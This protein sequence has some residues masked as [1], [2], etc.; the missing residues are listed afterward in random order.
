MKRAQIFFVFS[1]TRR[2]APPSE[3]TFLNSQDRLVLHTRLSWP[4]P[5]YTP[6]LF[7]TPAKQLLH[8]YALAGP[9]GSNA[10]NG[11]SQ[12][13]K[14]KWFTVA[15]QMVVFLLYLLLQC[16]L[17]LFA[18]ALVVYIWK[19]NVVITS[20]II[21][22]TLCATPA[23]LLFYLSVLFKIGPLHSLSC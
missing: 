19:I 9:S 1:F 4:W 13:P 21:A 18:C 8:L 16:G 20:L 10:E 6:V 2:T 15:V 17:L 14:P 23:W 12:Q 7:T 3:A 11:Q 22:L 5:S